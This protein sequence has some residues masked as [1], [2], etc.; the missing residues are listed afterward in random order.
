VILLW[1]GCGLPDVIAPEAVAGVVNEM[2]ASC[3]REDDWAGSAPPDCGMMTIWG[4]RELLAE[5]F[6]TFF[7]F[8]FSNRFSAPEMFLC[9]ITC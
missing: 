2:E 5:A 4:G 3:G 8:S 7:A 1:G 9:M 6:L